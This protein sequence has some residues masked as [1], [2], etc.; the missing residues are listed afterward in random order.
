MWFF[1]S[2]QIVYGEDALSFLSTINIGR[3]VI[4]VDR[5]LMRTQ[6]PAK[7]A[8]SLPAGT[9]QMFIGDIP[10]EPTFEQMNRHS[11]E[12]RSFEPDWFIALGGGSTIDSAKV[13]FAL[14]ERP[15]I[16]FYDITPLVRLDL[17]KRS[18]LIAI[19]TTSGTG[20]DCSWAAVVTESEEKRKSELASPEIMPDISIL[21]P[22]MVISLP[23][24]QTRNTAV[25]AITHSVEAY[26]STWQNPYSD[27]LAEKSFQM[28]TAF[29]PEVMAKPSDMH[30]RGMVHVAASMA[31]L[32]FSNSQIGLAHALGHA[33]G[34]R[35]HIAHGKAVGLFLPLVI[36]FNYDVRKEK[37]DT[38]NRLMPARLRGERL[39]KSIIS[40]FSEIGQPTSLSG[41]GID[42]GD[43]VA[44]MESLADM[45]MES[46]GM[47]TNPRDADSAQLRKFFRQALEG[48]V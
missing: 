13:L 24:E 22:A 37:Y 27:A 26:V 46:T 4:V 23:P 8:S 12:I 29:L 15:D 38:L 20:S 21:D 40:L 33:L 42:V 43:Y 18:R 1:R 9:K 14:Y 31:G 17:R 34:G 30:F 36:D 11:D 10:E 28:L 2:P 41:T 45:A 44:G 6:L 32:A 39:D 47:T 5:N 35:Y 25:D 48:M 7:I 3:A 19:P 16:N